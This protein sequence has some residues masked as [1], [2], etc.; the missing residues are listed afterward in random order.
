MCWIGDGLFWIY[1]KLQRH[2][3][4]GSRQ[5]TVLEGTSI[6]VC[7]L[8]TLT[9]QNGLIWSAW[10]APLTDHI[11]VVRRFKHV[12]FPSQQIC[13]DRQWLSYLSGYLLDFFRI[14]DHGNS[15]LDFPTMD[16]I[17]WYIYIYHLCCYP[18]VSTY[19]RSATPHG[20]QPS[21]VIFAIARKH[22]ETS[23][24]SEIMENGYRYNGYNGYIMVI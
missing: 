15:Q 24:P 22:I 12:L 20:P 6:N 10:L 19:P 11:Y 17:C 9:A 7:C 21:P 3:R 5:V 2:S 4:G 16:A 8:R 13:H 18:H 23:N 14:F 1:F